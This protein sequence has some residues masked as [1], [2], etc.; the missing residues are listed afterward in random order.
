MVTKNKAEKAAERKRISLLSRVERDEIV[1]YFQNGNGFN[2]L[3]VYDNDQLS[4][5]SRIIS[6][7]KGWEIP[8][9]AYGRSKELKNSLRETMRA[10]ILRYLGDYIP[11]G[12]TIMVALED[13]KSPPR[14][15]LYRRYLT[16]SEK[17]YVSS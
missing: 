4:K 11:E 2:R 17:S 13:W 5:E 14:L 12:Q 7:P 8:E 3:P 6:D 15:V 10:W 16:D 1:E 9:S